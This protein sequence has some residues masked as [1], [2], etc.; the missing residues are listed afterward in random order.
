VNAR[1]ILLGSDNA[2]R[3]RSHACA[4]NFVDFDSKLGEVFFVT[5]CMGSNDA[6]NQVVKFDNWDEI[7]EEYGELSWDDI[8]KNRDLLINEDIIIACDCPANL[9]W[10]Y[11]YIQTELDIAIDPE[12][13]FPSIRNPSL[14]GV[15]C[16][17]LL[18]VLDRFFT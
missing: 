4:P 9:Y 13:R 8:K 15:A 3:A 5:R 16:K 1:D 14:E 12:N 11:Q 7:L 17:H 2:S 18:A 10:G 6:W